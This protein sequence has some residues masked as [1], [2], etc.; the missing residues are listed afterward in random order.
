MPKIAKK[1]G[2]FLV[3]AER[4][5]GLIH[6]LRGQKVMLDAD[7][8][9]LYGVET[10]VLVRAVTRHCKRFPPDFMFRLHQREF[11]RLRCQFGISNARGGRRYR[12]YAFTEQGVAMLSSV[13]NTD[14]AVDVNIEIMRAFARLRRVL[15]SN[16]TLA[17][18]LDALERKYDGRFAEVFEAIRLL[19]K[20]DVPARGRIGFTS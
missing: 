11:R 12:P 16:E 17:K 13:L 18:K 19:M 6:F 2:A 1:S 14:R 15:E 8:A 10:G 5:A 7:L 20:P 9:D 3:P 4:I